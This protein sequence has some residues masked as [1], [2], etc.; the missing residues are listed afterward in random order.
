MNPH[1]LSSDPETQTIRILIAD[2]HTLF[3]Q[4]LRRLLDSEGDFTVVGEASDGIE[5]VQQAEL[6]RPDVVVMDVSMPRLNGMETVREIHRLLPGTPVIL[7][8][9]HE[10]PFVPHEGM[11]LGAS[12]YLLKKSV[13]REVFQ[14]IREV[15][16]GK[17]YFQPL[18]PSREKPRPLEI[19]STYEGLSSREKEVLRHLANGMTNPEIA[20]YLGISVNTVE[21]HRKNLM[22]KLGFHSLSDIIRFALV[23]GMI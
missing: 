5:A 21:T 8:T 14:A 19:P 9:M 12:G 6:L 1:S 23:H 13:D 18:P 7:L 10:D 20:D 2:D 22:K 3:R 15:H 4:G 11:R 16:A 17:T